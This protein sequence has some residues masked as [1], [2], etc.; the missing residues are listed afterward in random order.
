MKTLFKNLCLLLLF[1]NNTFAQ[2]II[3]HIEPS[4]WWI[5][6]KNPKVQIMLHGKN[7]AEL[8]PSLNYSGV[9]I[10]KI[11]KLE[12]P[13]YLFIDLAISPSAKAGNVAISFKKAGKT[14]ESTNFVL[15]NRITNAAQRKSYDNSDVIYLIAPDRFANG[16][17]ENDNTPDTIEK[18]NRADKDS[19]HGGDIRGII[20][21]LDYIKDMGFTTLWSMPL[22]ENNQE[23][24]TYHGY[25]IS[26]FY[27]IDPRY[28]TNEEFRELSLKAQE[29]GLKTIMDIV[30][31][32]CGIAH[33]WM[34]DLPSKD[35]INFEGKFSSTNHQR[36]IHQDI[37]AS[38]I[39]AKNHVEGWFVPSMPDMNQRNPFMANYLIQNT[40]WWIEYAQLAG[41]RID[42]Y[43]YSDKKFLAN[44]SKSILDEYPNLN[45]VGE[46]WSLKPSVISYWQKGKKNFDGY[47][48]SLPSL[49]DFPLQ[50]AVSE[51]MNEEDSHY[52][53]GLTK[54][55]QTLAEDFLYP[56]SDN[57]VI[58]PDNHDMSRFFTQVKENP[59]LFKMGLAFLLTH[60]PSSNLLHFIIAL[61]FS[62]LFTT[63]K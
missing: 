9:K 32:H 2:S 54:I 19:R 56:N 44:W 7:I 48:S 22:T 20:N 14:I 57:L 10:T 13:N 12:N 1:S 38:T 17:P 4:S 25:A 33:Y 15:N 46:E 62:N 50:N 28:G 8:T 24:V 27:K 34:K 63:S 26:N 16:N 11:S 3:E 39:D 42:T 23:R 35:W 59:A 49:M 58:F 21:H 41:L 5:G 61:H 51:A 36:Q 47:V 40:I 18:A 6:M 30:L 60:V 52:N 31:N 45:M 43:P 29:K 37:H 55:Y 53:K